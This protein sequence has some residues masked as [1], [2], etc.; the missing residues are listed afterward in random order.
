MLALLAACAGKSEPGPAPGEVNVAA[1]PSPRERLVNEAAERILAGAK[2][3]ESW[4]ILLSVGPG[5]NASATAEALRR[6]LARDPRI[7][8][9][10]S[11]RHHGEPM[12]DP[13]VPG[14]HV[15]TEEWVFTPPPLLVVRVF[16]AAG[17]L[18]I[19]AREPGADP[20]GPPVDGW[21]WQLK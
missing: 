21:L 13:S 19:A 5:E 4:P 14:G 11:E 2:P 8:W 15:N 16:E 7:A 18:T 9:T 6:A 3:G 10:K 17:V 20:L 12:A 1:D